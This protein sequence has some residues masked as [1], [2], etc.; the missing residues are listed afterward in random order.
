MLALLEAVALAVHLQDVHMVGESVQQR[1][2]Q[3]LRAQH[4]GPLL[5]GQVAGHQR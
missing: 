1:T 4:F 2:G 5:K 3:P